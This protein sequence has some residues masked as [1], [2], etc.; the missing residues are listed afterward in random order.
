MDG[1][2][3]SM[4]VRGSKRQTRT[5]M[6]DDY[7]LSRQDKYNQTYLAEM[8]LIKN[9]LVWMAYSPKSAD[10]SEY[11]DNGKCNFIVPFG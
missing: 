3:K 2:Q 1:R 7:L 9:N 8:D 11:C 5:V 10:E 4:F 6:L